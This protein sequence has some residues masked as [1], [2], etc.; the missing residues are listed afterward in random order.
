M[1][2]T[3][4]KHMEIRNPSGVPRAKASLWGPYGFDEKARKR[5]GAAR[6]NGRE[7]ATQIL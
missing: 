1:Q 3:G 5:Q 2:A 4:A 6:E 7:T